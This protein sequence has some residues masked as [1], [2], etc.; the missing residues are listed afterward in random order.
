MQLWTIVSPDREWKQYADTLML[1]ICRF[2]II[3]VYATLSKLQYY[4]IGTK[5]EIIWINTAEYTDLT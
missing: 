3:Q 4:V 5:L 1:L 2:Q